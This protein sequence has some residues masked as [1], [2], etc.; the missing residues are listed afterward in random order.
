MRITGRRCFSVATFAPL[1]EIV[2]LRFGF[3]SRQSHP[4]QQRGELEVAVIKFEGP[5]L[6]CI[7]FKQSMIGEWAAIDA[8]DSIVTPRYKALLS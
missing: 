8:S 2:G 5:Q 6:N 7:V 4:E 1:P 3:F